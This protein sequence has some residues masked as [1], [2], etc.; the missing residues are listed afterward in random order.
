VARVIAY[1]VTSQRA[2]AGVAE[3]ADLRRGERYVRVNIAQDRGTN[4][5]DM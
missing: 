4:E 1:T 5:I 2:H 3:S